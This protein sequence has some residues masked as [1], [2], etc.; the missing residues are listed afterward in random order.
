MRFTE[1]FG[2][3]AFTTHAHAVSLRD[4]GATHR[5]A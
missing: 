2:D 3:L 4:L 1:T 5:A